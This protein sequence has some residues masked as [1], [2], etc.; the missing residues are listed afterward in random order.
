MIT[1]KDK[2]SMRQVR[3]TGTPS[4]TQFVSTYRV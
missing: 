3:L 1:E 4:K 2:K